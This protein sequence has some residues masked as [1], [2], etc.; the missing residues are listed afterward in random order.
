MAGLALEQDEI[1]EEAD[2]EE[3]DANSLQSKRGRKLVKGWGKFIQV[4]LLH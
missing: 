1:P 3:P 4:C 2:G